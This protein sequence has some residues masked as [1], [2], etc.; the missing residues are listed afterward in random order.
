MLLG[1]FRRSLYDLV[2]K[3]ETRRVYKSEYSI[4][5]CFRIIPEHGLFLLQVCFTLTK[6]WL[7][8]CITLPSVSVSNG[9]FLWSLSRGEE[10][11]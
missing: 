11:C 6:H 4:S 2:L 3:W 8:A 1:A 5:G 10:G 7:S 9:R